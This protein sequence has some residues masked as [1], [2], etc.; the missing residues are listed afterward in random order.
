MSLRKTQILFFV[1]ALWPSPSLTAQD[2]EV[3]PEKGNVIF[4]HPDGSGVSAWSAARLLTVGPDGMLNWDRMERIGIY[5]GHMKD[6]MGASSH[7]GGTSHAYGVK[8][9]WDSYGMHGAEPL[10]SLSGKPFS[11]L[12]EAHAAG[13]ATA[14]VNSGHL[15]EPG[16]GVFAASAPSR[17]DTDDIT[18]Q[19]IQSGTEIILGGG[20]VLLLPEGVMGKF[21]VPGIRKD[22]LNLIE[23]AEELGY[24]VVYTREEL[25]ELPPE[26]EKVLGVFGAAHTFVDWSEERL[27]ESPYEQYWY[28]S[29]TIAEMT[30][31][32]LRFLEASDRQFLLVVEEEGSDNFANNNNASGA[33]NALARADEAVGVAM[34]FVERNPNTLLVTTADSDAGGIEVY[35][36]RDP[37]SLT[38]EMPLPPTTFNGAPLDGID[39]TETP[40]FLSMPDQFG[41]QWP[42]GIVWSSFEDNLGGNVAKAHGLNAG[43][44]PLNTDN[45]DIYRLMYGTLFGIWLK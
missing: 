29:P 8:V 25:L 26:T 35:P 24:E 10:T 11:I 34:E 41:K 43:L 5:R 17:S 31:A 45:T 13:L 39:G 38:A 21:R 20:E 2:G 6:A 37:D 9:P 40:P 30:Q 44:L 15:A 19:I 23:R 16:T 14:L 1:F 4:I 28:W 27:R 18:R 33:L 22:G 32:A 7:G 12:T 3:R 42:F 36:I